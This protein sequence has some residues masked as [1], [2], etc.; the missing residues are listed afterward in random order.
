MQT[1]RNRM[2][3]SPIL[4][5]DTVSRMVLSCSG[6]KTA[7]INTT[8]RK[9]SSISIGL[10]ACVSVR[11]ALG[12]SRNA[13]RRSPIH[14]SRGILNASR[15]FFVMIFPN[16]FPVKT[17]SPLSLPIDLQNQKDC[18]QHTPS[19]IAAA[20]YEKI[21]KLIVPDRKLS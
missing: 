8:P 3:S 6:K 2:V 12:K 11:P 9:G 20:V 7:L 18:D 1:L 17:H 16:T 5:Q 13:S 4:L 21:L 19:Q 15:R 10:A 14:K